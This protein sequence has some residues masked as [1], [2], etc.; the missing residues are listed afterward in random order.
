MD[1]LVANAGA[2]WGGPFETFDDWKSAKT[3]DLNVR[4]VFNLVRF[5]VP[6]LSGAGTS[7]DPA[8]VIIISS[9]AGI[10]ISHVGDRGAIMYSASKAAVHHLGRNLALELV[11]KH[12]TTNI[13]SP[14]FF[15]TRLALPQIDYLWG[16]DKAAGSNPMGRLGEAED[17]AGAIVYLCS[18]AGAYVNG[19][20]TSLDG[21]GRLRT[22]TQ[23][24]HGGKL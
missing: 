17:V 9:I 6:L 7:Q 16:P 22:G 5:M 10:A 21:G 24:D 11:P 13:I 20:N 2:S 23:L 1:I 18:R 4:G 12:I 3:L 15:P 8:R 19:E 14:G